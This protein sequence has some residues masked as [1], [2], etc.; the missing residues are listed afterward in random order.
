[1]VVDRPNGNGPSFPVLGEPFT[2]ASTGAP[3]VSLFLFPG[4]V[5][6]ADH[7]EVTTRLWGM[8]ANGL[9]NLWRWRGLRFDALAGFRTLQFFESVTLGQ[10]AQ[11]AANAPLVGGEF[12]AGVDYFG[13]T[14]NFYRRAS[15]PA[16]ARSAAAGSSWT[17]RPR[18]PWEAPRKC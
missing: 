2:N 7:V 14:N 9:A 13:V 5:T 10:Q 17:C 6:G 12:A 8:D 18:P 11:V 15:R 16:R 3:D 1:M 4:L